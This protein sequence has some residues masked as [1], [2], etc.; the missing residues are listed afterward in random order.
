MTGVSEW[1]PLL[2]SHAYHSDEAD[3]LTNLFKIVLACGVFTEDRKSR[4]QFERG[5]NLDRDQER[6]FASHSE[7]SSVKEYVGYNGKTDSR[8][9]IPVR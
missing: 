2:L 8:K 9:P 5:V 4:L 6:F 1:P 7:Y 3:K